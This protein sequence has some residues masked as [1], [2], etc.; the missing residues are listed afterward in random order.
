[1]GFLSAF[2]L[3]L[4]F[5]L[6]FTT[7][8]A[9][10]ARNSRS[11]IAIRQSDQSGIQ[12][13]IDTGSASDGAGSGFNIPAILWLAFGLLVGLY[14]TLGGMRLWRV[15]TALAIGLVLALCGESSIPR[16]WS[17]VAILM[18]PTSSAVWVAI[19]NVM[20]AQGL[21]DLVL[22][23]VTLGFFAIGSLGGL[24]RICRLAGLTALSILSGMSLGMRLV[25]MREGLL[26][27]PIS[28]N[29]IIIVVC[30]VGG[31]VITLLRQ[32]IGIVRMA[33]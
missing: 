28:L 30:A 9:F 26:L 29:W 27:R 7:A 2:T 1:M 17:S 16:W 31:C 20:N 11:S 18:R 14:L 4:T 8:F 5:L 10:P 6:W 21:S 13:G 33:V 22:A 15:T 25:L 23:L 24:F 12:S 3:R 32:R 19:V